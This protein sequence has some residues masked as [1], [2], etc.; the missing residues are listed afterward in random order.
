MTNTHPTTHG[1]GL[2]DARASALS[3]SDDWHERDPDFNAYD[4][5]QLEREERAA[6]EA[7]E[8]DAELQSRAKAS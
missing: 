6:S 5:D 8:V 3:D 2:F 4:G 1:S 7:R